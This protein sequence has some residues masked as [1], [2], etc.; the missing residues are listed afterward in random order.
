MPQS[1]KTI[2]D[3]ARRDPV[4][5]CETVLG[6]KPWPIQAEILLA[7]ARGDREINVASC[8][9]AGKSWIAAVAVLWFLFC[10]RRSVVLTTAPTDR[11]VRGILWKEIRS[12]HRDAK[13]SLGGKPTTQRIELSEDWFA[14][15]F[16]APDF[17]PTRFQGWHAPHV[18]VVV[19]EAA[20]VT[21]EIHTAIAGTLSGEH[22][23]KLS[24]GNPTDPLS[25]FAKAC[26]VASTTTFHVSAFDTPNF[27][28][29]GITEED[30]EN[31]IWREKKTDNNPMPDLVT[32]RWVAERYE[33][34]GPSHPFYISRVLGR[35]PKDT[36]DALIPMTWI[37]EAQRRTIKPTENDRIILGLDVAREGADETAC[38]ERWGGRIRRVFV[39]RKEDTMKTVARARR[40]I[41]TTEADEIN[42]D[43]V[44]LGAGVY[45]RL[46][47][48][49]DELQVEINS[50]K[51]GERANDPEKFANL[52]AELYWQERERY[53]RGEIDID[54]EDEQ[55]A[56]QAAGVKWSLD[57][58][59]RIAVERKEVAKKKRGA[60]SPDR[61]EAAVYS[62]AAG[63]GWSFA[64]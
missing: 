9:G 46:V 41:E 43:A 24:I 59:G 50:I 49:E 62:G 26:D 23:I 51:F 52:K 54:P 2:L 18:L 37:Q 22:A 40:A 30:I 32:P 34:W 4:W 10:F 7:M 11:Q 57:S 28:H 3:R 20:G 31:G 5:W 15:G 45:D 21:E 58:K 38:Y 56:E 39:S 48:L 63:L 16:T 27:T 14:W 33:R 25:A 19:D 6:K 8:H 55:L 60:K 36:D 42:I 53:E 47:E 13:F 12:L 35:F 64:G 61:F 44:G 17:D 29:W 1:A